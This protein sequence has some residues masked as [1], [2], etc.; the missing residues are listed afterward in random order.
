VH[1]FIDGQRANLERDVA[2]P[3]DL[4]AAPAGADGD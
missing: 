3:R 4:A 2:G 1:L